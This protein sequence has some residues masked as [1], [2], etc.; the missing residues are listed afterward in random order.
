MTRAG[1]VLSWLVVRRPY[2]T[3]SLFTITYSLTKAPARRPLELIKSF[4][5]S[6]VDWRGFA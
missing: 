6:Q 2:F 3:Y 1:D 4:M 5:V